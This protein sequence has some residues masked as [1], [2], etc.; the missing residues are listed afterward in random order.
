MRA[1]GSPRANEPM[2]GTSR[3]VYVV[4]ARRFDST[5]Q[6]VCRT[7]QTERARQKYAAL[8]S[9]RIVARLRAKAAA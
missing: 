4:E 3:P 8:A 1:L 5:W 6:E 9:Q 2:T 7:V